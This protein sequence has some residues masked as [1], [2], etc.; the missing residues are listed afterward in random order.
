MGNTS[1]LHMLCLKSKVKISLHWHL[2]A[3]N[4]SMA[5]KME[6]P[7]ERDIRFICIPERTCFYWS[8]LQMKKVYTSVEDH[9][10]SAIVSE[11]MVTNTP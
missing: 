4:L 3:K 6:E 5:S 11:E 7:G 9:L 10:S 2:K 1:P 8:L